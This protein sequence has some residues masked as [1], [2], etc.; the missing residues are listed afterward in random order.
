[1]IITMQNQRDPNP[2]PDG[3]PFPERHGRVMIGRMAKAGGNRV[4]LAALVLGLA[5]EPVASAARK[6]APKAPV[7]L[8][9]RVSL[10]GFP[11]A[12]VNLAAAIGTT[13]RV[14][15]S[16]RMT[17]LAGWFSQST[18]NGQ[19]EGSAA[20][21]RVV[22]SSYRV[23]F[24]GSRGAQVVRVLLNVGN[25]STA[26]IEPPL[27]PRP[28]RVPLE[29]SHKRGVL[30][31]LSAMIILNPGTGPMLD[32]AVCN[33]TLPIFDGAGRYDI[34]LS[35]A[36]MKTVAIEGYHGPALACAARYTP[37]AGHR[38]N[39]AGVR[40][41]EQNREL[42]TWLIPVPG[43]RALIPVRYH[44][45]TMV[46]ALVIEA[47]HFASIETASDAPSPGGR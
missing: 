20:D 38:L 33:R 41:M 47:R 35:Y 5:L 2:C 36:G 19:S 4:W 6:S 44:I 24:G 9:Y 25:V 42:E 18:G 1:M 14:V 43:T 28:D 10:A 30:D 22:P 32:P 27:D 39:R 31:P 7:E 13:Y 12:S 34:T 26:T 16:G 40:F 8:D 45:G 15:L 46:G 29:D 3:R 17:G 37:V 11:I 21:G 23:E